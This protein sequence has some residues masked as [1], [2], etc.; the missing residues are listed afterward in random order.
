MSTAR[1]RNLLVYVGI[2]CADMLV[3]SAAA[4]LGAD[5]MPGFRPG[6]FLAPARTSA[7]TLLA[8]VAPCLSAWLASNRPRFG[9][10]PIAAQVNA[11]S[12]RG[13]PRGEMVVLTQG[14]AAAAIASVP[15][16]DARRADLREQVRPWGA[17]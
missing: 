16:D 6:E 17:C 5:A 10:E 4:A 15:A 7:V 1:L 14:E 11:L 8:V 9:S 13:V 3:I 2:A 12:E